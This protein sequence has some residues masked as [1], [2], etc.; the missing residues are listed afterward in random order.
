MCSAS[1]S[2]VSLM[3]FLSILYNYSTLR[4]YTCDTKGQKH[5]FER[6]KNRSFVSPFSSSPFCPFNL[7]SYIR[8]QPCDR[9]LNNT[10]TRRSAFLR[11]LLFLALLFFLALLQRLLVFGFLQLRLLFFF[12]VR[13]LIALRFFRW[14]VALRSTSSCLSKYLKLF[15]DQITR[16]I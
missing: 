6:K 8:Y 16:T 3:R 13:A 1:P 10:Y 2:R 12:F 14:C 11:L 15:V 5:L 9:Y 4:R 7:L